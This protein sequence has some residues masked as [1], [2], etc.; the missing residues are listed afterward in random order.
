MITDDDGLVAKSN[1]L[2]ADILISLG[3]LWDSLFKRAFVHH[4]CSQAL[5]VKGNHESNS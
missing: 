3:D 1:S 4:G 2:A 5:A